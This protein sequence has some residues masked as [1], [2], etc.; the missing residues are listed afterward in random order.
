M[1]K[2]SI[3]KPLRFVVLLILFVAIPFARHR[4]RS[5]VRDYINQQLPHQVTATELEYAELIEA[6]TNKNVFVHSAEL[7]DE[8]NGTPDF[9]KAVFAVGEE[10]VYTDIGCAI[11]DKQEINKQV[12][13][14]NVVSGYDNVL[15]KTVYAHILREDE[16]G[17]TIYEFDAIKYE[18]TTF[19]VSPLFIA[20]DS[21]IALVEAVFYNGEKEICNE[22]HLEN[23]YEIADFDRHNIDKICFYDSE[24]NLLSEY[25]N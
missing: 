25:Y 23:I 4:A 5:Y 24:H 6:K 2:K 16:S 10:G 15:D 20:A 13:F 11:F 7:Y 1:E 18:N 9:A 21:H 19:S 3:K 8:I 22:S 12:G 17:F 14:I